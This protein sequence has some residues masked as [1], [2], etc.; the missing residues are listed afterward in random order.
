M[1][2]IA[3]AVGA[4]VLLTT[5]NNYPVSLVFANVLLSFHFATAIV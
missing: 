5:G 2:R 3:E 4:H 1:L